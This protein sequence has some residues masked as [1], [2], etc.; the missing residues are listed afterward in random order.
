MFYCYDQNNSS[1]VW[2]VDEKLSPMLF[3][4]ADSA[5]QANEIAESLGCYFDGVKQGRDCPCCGDRWIRNYDHTRL[6][7]TDNR[8]IGEEAQDLVDRLCVFYALGKDVSYPEGRIY[9][10]DG[11]VNDVRISESVLAD[12][13]KH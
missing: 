2:H 6:D 10:A 11:R 1:G 3:I 4:E 13:I 9:Y 8:S 7:E 12:Y 5:E